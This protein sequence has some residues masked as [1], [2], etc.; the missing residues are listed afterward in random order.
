[1]KRLASFAALLAVGSF[2]F[3]GCNKEEG[4]P[5]QQVGNAV[6]H[7][8][9]ATTRGVNDASK[10][11]TQAVGN[12]ATK[13]ASAMA[14]SGTGDIGGVRNAVEGIVTN[15]LDRNNWGA[16]TDFFTKAD[17]ER[18]T[19]TKPDT[20][21][22]DAVITRVKQA[23]HDKYND[24]FSVMSADQV[25]NQSFLNL[26]HGAAGDATQTAS[27]SI[28]ASH[29]MP[30]LNLTTVA[31][32]GKWKIDVPD[33]V[34]GKRLHDNLLK[35]LSDLHANA[36]T[37]PADKTQAYQLITHRILMAVLNEGA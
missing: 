23:W 11:T 21:D 31:E 7:G 26:S 28:A 3:A 34:D 19:N 5:G 9:D 12:A 32:G 10:A 36:A 18:L 37:W 6:Q 4:T 20:A 27:A 35:A 22:L 17:K 8:V 30:A 15:A 14:P 33:T 13:A 29:G 2:G 24:N 1:M 16:M 25:Y